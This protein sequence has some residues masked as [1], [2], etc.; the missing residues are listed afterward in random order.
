MEELDQG[1]I[2]EFGFDPVVFELLLVHSVWGELSE[3][4]ENGGIWERGQGQTEIL[5]SYAL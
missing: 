3:T 4:N 5:V 2:N 1:D